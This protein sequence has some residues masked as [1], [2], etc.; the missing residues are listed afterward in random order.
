MSGIRLSEGRE[1]STGLLGF[2]SMYNT[3]LDKVEMHTLIQI[4]YIIECEGIIN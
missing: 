4:I 2:S 3:D 1:S